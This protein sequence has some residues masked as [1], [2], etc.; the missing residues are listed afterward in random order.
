[1]YRQPHYTPWDADTN[2]SQYQ[3][4]AG[5]HTITPTSSG[6]SY[7][8]RSPLPSS[9]LPFANHERRHLQ[10]P[11]RLDSGLVE[12]KEPLTFESLDDIIPPSLDVRSRNLCY[13]ALGFAW[14][15]SITCTTVAIYILV[16]GGTQV[17]DWLV[18]RLA[19]VGPIGLSWTEMP[20]G[21]KNVYREDH[22]V[23]KVPKGVMVITSL[24]LSVSLT[25][26]FDCIH[27]IH[28]LSLRWQLWEEGG[29]VYNSNPRLFSSTKRHGPNKW[30]A[31]IISAFALVLG[32]GGLS[33]MTL[34][35]V[36]V[37]GLDPQGN[38]KY[39]L[40][41]IFDGPRYGLDFNAWGMLGLGFGLLLQSIIST[42]CL[43][44]T[45]H[46]IGT[47]NSNP[48]AVARACKYID[49]QN[50][51][52]S[53]T[54]RSVAVEQGTV[55]RSSS[56][57]SSAAANR[58]SAQDFPMYPSNSRPTTHQ[59]SGSA[60]TPLSLS[61]TSF[62]LMVCSTPQKRQPCAGFFVPQTKR[63]VGALWFITAL[64]AIWTIVV[65]IEAHKAGTVTRAYV[66]SQGTTPNPDSFS[67]WQFFGQ[68]NIVYSHFTYTSKTEW[69]GLLIETCSLA[70]PILGIHY[71][72]SVF[73][74]VRDEAIWR[75]AATKRGANPDSM[76]LL[77]NGRCWSQWLLFSIKV[78]IPWTFSF[79][80]SCNV[81]VFMA[82]IPVCTFTFL[83]LVLSLLSGY[84]IWHQPHGPQPPTYGNIAALIGLVEDWS[85]KKIYWGDKGEY[86]KGIR[87][88]G[89]SGEP[90]PALSEN[91]MYTGL[92]LSQAAPVGRTVDVVRGV[93]IEK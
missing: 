9:H 21:F 24:L 74:L 65:S 77:E 30:Y 60:T 84:M 67:F 66:I 93:M 53:M 92:R 1:M 79:A 25:Y 11:L 27:F 16:K 34:P 15:I 41:P 38:N 4:H 39:N 23:F 64:A 91:A 70:L 44:Q 13:V 63:I 36:V 57:Y 55:H 58:P 62:Q 75:G 6:Q 32:Y 47:W 72:E 49:D 37:D 89:T 40:N 43:V 61:S 18:N 28:E 83:F 31:N 90:L 54:E 42:W 2:G 73:Q 7:V 56:I 26:V 19:A 45:R 3:V 82:I 20:P 8:P 68:I 88:A 69:R 17:P 85:Q 78:L 5:D 86:G 35:V 76:I 10:V 22:R 50:N 59:S 71:A 80:I 14:A 33:V 29:L 51:P 52:K 48:L 87:L 12:P 46:S 81:A